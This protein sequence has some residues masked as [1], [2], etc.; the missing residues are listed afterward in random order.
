MTVPDPIALS[1]ALIRC[2]SVTPDDAGAI[3]VLETTLEAL[4]FGC[5]SL[6]FE[7]DGSLAGAHD[8]RGD[9]V[10]LGL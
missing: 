10:A 2:R 9:G 3:G 6:R 4:G 5:Q 8:P 7:A 1:Q